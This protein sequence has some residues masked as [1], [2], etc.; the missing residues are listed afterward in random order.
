MARRFHETRRERTSRFV[1]VGQDMVLKANNYE[2]TA[3]SYKFGDEA[4]LK[5]AK[6]STNRQVY[7]LE[8][9]GFVSQG[10]KLVVCVLW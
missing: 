2:V 8:R 4:P 7:R 6:K 9:G 5:I 3:S 1:Q 10:G